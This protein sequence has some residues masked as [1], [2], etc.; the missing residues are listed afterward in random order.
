MRSILLIEDN[1]AILENLKEYLELEGYYIYSAAT[2]KKGI[3]LAV[4]FKPDLVICA[5]PWP[6]IDGHQ[7]FRLLINTMTSHGI[8]YIFSS[9]ESDSIHRSETLGLGAADYIL[10]PFDLDNMLQKA[11]SCIKYGNKMQPCTI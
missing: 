4:E 8:P 11:E 2:E 6:G 7:D 3:D 10:K 5:M 9:T 1:V